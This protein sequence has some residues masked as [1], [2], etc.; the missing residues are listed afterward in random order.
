MDNTVTDSAAGSGKRAPDSSAPLVFGGESDHRSVKRALWRGLKQRCPQC[1][2][3]KL[4][5]GYTSVREHCGEC[6]LYLAG[7]QADDAPPYFTMIIAGH[8][9]IPMALEVKRHFHPPLGLQLLV[10]GI[11]MGLAI[12]WL[13]PRTKG[14][15][16]GVQWANR[17]HG[18]S[19]DPEEDLEHS[20]RT[21]ENA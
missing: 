13:L 12:W 7:H 8:A 3:G 11:V 16:I 4:F 17:M 20:L 5:K 21:E 2:E 6:G 9:I 1:G 10:W 15:L 18:F 14:A 19:D